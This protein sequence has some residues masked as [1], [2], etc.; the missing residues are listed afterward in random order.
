MSR[1]RPFQ[2]HPMTKLLL[3]LTLGGVLSCD[4][5][6]PTTPLLNGCSLT[7]DAQTARL[8]IGKDGFE[9][10]ETV[11]TA[12]IVGGYQGGHHLWAALRLPD[13]VDVSE[14]GRLHILACDGQNTIAKALYA[15]AQSVSQQNQDLFAIP[16]VFGPNQTV[17]DL[18]DQRLSL[19]AAV[20]HSEHTYVA[21]GEVVLRCC[22]HVAD[23]D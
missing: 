5:T 4:D 18:D 15:S 11:D 16:V 14:L 12:L 19:F 6:T 7:S 22:G 10:L 20:E 21:S 13:G 3:C 17:N 23:G 2:F 8:G 1:P 9:P